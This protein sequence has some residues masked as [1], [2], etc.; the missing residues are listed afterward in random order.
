MWPNLFRRQI[1]RYGSTVTT[2]LHV[3]DIMLTETM[4]RFLLLVASAFLL[5]ACGFVNGDNKMNL[6]MQSADGNIEKVKELVGKV[7]NVNFV[8]LKGETPLNAASHNGHVEV[9][10]FLIANGADCQYKD[11]Y[12]KTAYETAVEQNQSEVQSYLQ[13]QETCTK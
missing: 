4:T 7:R 2:N 11:G 13:S 12:G 6:T 9:V 10:K 3:Y 8:S 1:F 5:V